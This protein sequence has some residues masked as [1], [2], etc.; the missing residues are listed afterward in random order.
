MEVCLDGSEWAIGGVGDLR[1]GSLGEEPGATTSRYGS[2]SEATA[3]R[4]CASRSAR[5][6]E[7]A[8]STASPTVAVRKRSWPGRSASAASG[9]SHVT[10]LR[11]PARLMARRTAIRESQAP[12]GPSARHVASDRY[13]ITNASWAT[14]SASERSPSTRAQAAT[15]EA[16]SRSTSRRKASRSPARTASTIVRSSFVAPVSGATSRVPSSGR[17]SRQRVRLVHVVEPPVAGPSSDAIIADAGG[18]HRSW[19]VMILAGPVT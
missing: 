19:E 14:S 1:Q 12:N 6:T 10:C 18:S 11:C 13:A 4:S 8:G 9:S 2:S 17:S 7:W 3:A 16:P 15:T 5:S